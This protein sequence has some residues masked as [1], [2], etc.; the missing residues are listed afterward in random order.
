MHTYIHTHIHP[1]L[2]NETFNTNPEATLEKKNYFIFRY[3]EETKNGCDF[4]YKTDLI[5]DLMTIPG[6][7]SIA[8]VFFFFKY[9]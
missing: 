4:C 8:G 7:D 9:Y 2:G 6:R 1:S 5:I 3:F